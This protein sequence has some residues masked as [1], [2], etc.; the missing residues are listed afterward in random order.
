MGNAVN[1]ILTLEAIFWGVAPGFQ[2][3]GI[4]TTVVAAAR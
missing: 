1:I 2:L 4:T 3:S